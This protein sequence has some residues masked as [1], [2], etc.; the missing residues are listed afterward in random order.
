LEEDSKETSTVN[1]QLERKD[2]RRPCVVQLTNWCNGPGKNMTF[3]FLVLRLKEIGLKKVADTL[4]RKVLHETSEQLHRYFLDD[5]FKEMIPTQSL[6]LEKPQPTDEL[7]PAPDLEDKDEKLFQAV[8]ILVTICFTFCA[9]MGMCMGCPDLGRQVC[10]RV[11][12]EM[13]SACFDVAIDNCGRITKGIHQSAHRHLFMAPRGQ[14][15]G[16]FMV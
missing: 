13:C 16:A 12:P 8:V 15:G 9:C 11:C 14:G 7:V 2:A 10:K 1:S 3:D 4:S 6:M 5:P